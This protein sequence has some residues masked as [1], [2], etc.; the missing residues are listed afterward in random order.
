MLDA[1]ESAISGLTLDQLMIQGV[2]LLAMTATLSAFASRN[3]RRFFL[4]LIAG[5]SL[6]ALHFALLGAWVG[7]GAN[8]I[9]VARAW[10]A[11]DRRGPVTLALI[12]TAFATLAVL[13]V[14]TP[15]DLLA[16]AAPII[17][18]TA[19][20]LLSGWRMRSVML[21]CSMMWLTYNLAMGSWGG[22]LN[23]LAV[24]TINLV[25]IARLL[26][27]HRRLAGTASGATP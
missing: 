25:T 9:A 22:V 24:S 11:R 14:Q 3:D 20:F 15:V 5:H 26:A 6:F 17:G 23:E 10:F 4:I 19:M 2:G 18:T 7:M 12:L 21:L 1:L 13:T 16:A 8:I 27:A